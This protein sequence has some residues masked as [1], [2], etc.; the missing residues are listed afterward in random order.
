[1]L[2]W[3]SC[4]SV[5]A[6]TTQLLSS[7]FSCCLVHTQLL[8]LLHRCCSGIAYLLFEL[9]SCCIHYLLATPFTQLIINDCFYS[10]I[11]PPA[12][13]FVPSSCSDGSITA[14]ATQ[15]PNDTDNYFHRPGFWNLSWKYV[16]SFRYRVL[17]PAFTG[18]VFPCGSTGALG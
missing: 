14:L 4:C 9:L 7:C 6:A 13:E 8:V 10:S 2:S 16:H 15:F 11:T 5:A 17:R 1:M 3:L 12:A 18:P